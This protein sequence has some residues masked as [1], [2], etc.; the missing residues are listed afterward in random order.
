MILFFLCHSF[1]ELTH[2]TDSN[3]KKYIMLHPQTMLILYS[4]E[5][6]TLTSFFPS[7]K[8]LALKFEDKL[9]IVL[10]NI[11]LLPNFISQHPISTDPAILFFNNEHLIATYSKELNIKTFEKIFERLFQ[12]YNKPNLKNALDVYHFM[13]TVPVNLIIYDNFEGSY[14]K[15]VI[16]SIAPYISYINV[17]SISSQELMQELGVDCFPC[18]QISRQFDNFFLRIQ[19]YTKNSLSKLLRSFIQPIFIP[20]SFGSPVPN[21]KWILGALY[22]FS[23]PLQRA[24]VAEAFK[25][26]SFFDIFQNCSYQICDFMTC[27]NQTKHSGVYDSSEPVFLLFRSDVKNPSY[28]FGTDRSPYLLRFWLRDLLKNDNFKISSELKI[29]TYQKFEKYILNPSPKHMIVTYAIFYGDQIESNFYLALSQIIELQNKNDLDVKF[30]YYNFAA[31]PKI[32]TPK[33]DISSPCLYI[34][35]GGKLIGEIRDFHS[36]ESFQNALKQVYMNVSKISQTDA[37]DNL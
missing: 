37:C 11:S 29:L 33:L 25:Y 26:L 35:K 31:Q 24:E 23:N 32:G 3:V 30:F 21:R 36:L 28:F 10:G 19:N 5:F 34:Y 1:Q 8:N 13:D 6:P 4:K 22:D 20:E 18:I 7:F 2:I 15:N 12:S 14:Y 27:R 16:N 17:G 9:N